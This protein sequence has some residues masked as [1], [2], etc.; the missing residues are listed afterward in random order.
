[1]PKL[2]HTAEEVR[3]SIT[4]ARA[5]GKTIGL[6]PTMGALHDGHLSLADA[7][8]SECTFT[9]ATIFVNP[10]QFAPN[11]DLAKYPRN[12]DADMQALARHD[13]DQVFAPSPAEVYPE[14]FSTYVDPPEVAKPL[15][16]K[17]RPGH[18]RGVCT[19]VLKLFNLIPADIAYFGEK[20]YQQL[21]VIR[22]M[23][24]DLNLPI[25]IRPCPT[26]REPDGLA[27]SSRNVYLNGDERQ[28]ALALSNSLA[29]AND[30]V[31]SGVTKSDAILQE[32]L[33]VFS[34]AGVENI[35]YIALVDPETL[36]DV[37][38]I[39]GPTQ[40]LVAAYVGKTRLI[41]NR[42]IG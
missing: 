39:T 40:A 33:G 17:C 2:I 8:K 4:I 10:T 14:G 7:A 29:M 36:Q 11:E 19:V 42:R 22:H 15:E 41:D 5:S 32:M 13:V 37:P 28:Q 1:M 9:I 25:E 27:M 23:A 18:F 30:L 31:G 16:G 34:N 3:Q 35:D 21:L 38:T 26:L 20:D 12:L 6:V 24:R